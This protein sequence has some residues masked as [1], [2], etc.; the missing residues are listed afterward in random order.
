MVD[1]IPSD[2]VAKIMEIIKLEYLHFEEA[3]KT[4]PKIEF[5]RRRTDPVSEKRQLGLLVIWGDSSSE[6]SGDS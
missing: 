3:I 4:P 1:S 2:F 5:S 6:F